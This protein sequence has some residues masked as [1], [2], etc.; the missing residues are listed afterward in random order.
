MKQLLALLILLGGAAL[1]AAN[2]PAAPTCTATN[3]VAATVDAVMAN[4]S[5][6]L[7]KCA[8]V[9]G[10][11]H[12]RTLFTSVDGYYR[13]GPLVGGDP[14]SNPNDKFRIHL[15]NSAI[16]KR[17]PKRGFHE[18][19]AVGRIQDCDEMRSAVASSAP[20][21]AIVMIAGPCH[22]ASGP[23]VWT[24]DLRIVR[25]LKPVRL[26]GE[27]AS[28]R[29]GSLSPAPAGWR[30]RRKVEAMAADYLSVLRSGDR[31]RFLKLH[32]AGE[33]PNG[34]AEADARLAFGSHRGFMALR[35][36][37]GPVETAILIEHAAGGP[38]EEEDDY[39]SWI[40]FCVE[41]TCT[42][43]WPISA[44]DADNRPDRPYVCT[45]LTPYQVV[46]AGVEPAFM[47]ERGRYGLEEPRA[48]ERR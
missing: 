7:H 37:S 13:A 22:Y 18:A 39:A 48:K 21:D 23:V 25:E 6:Y 24:T 12:G 47:T 2:R 46:R 36:S 11:L 5:T 30:E 20:P 10:L 17:L 1:A 8:A 38:D 40:C 4:P 34:D 43:R 45:K 28:K 9:R 32:L 29:V 31:K 15:D 26:M 3:A 19:I 27:A 44:I 33:R 14:D 35:R 41:A 42:G 16:V